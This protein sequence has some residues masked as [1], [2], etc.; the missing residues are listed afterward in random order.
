MATLSPD[1][2]AYSVKAFCKAHGISPAFFYVMRSE[3]WGPAE[4]YAGQRVLI[5]H[6]AA[7]RW[8]R[9]RERA[10]ATGQRRY[11]RPPKKRKAG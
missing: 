3:G 11:V 1:G 10:A 4:M 9:M 2:G 7:A 5:S 6:E 8:R